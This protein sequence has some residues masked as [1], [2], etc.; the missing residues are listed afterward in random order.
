MAALARARP[1]H[2]GLDADEAAAL[3]RAALVH[4]LGRVGVPNGVWDKPGPLSDAEWER[5]RLHSYYTERILARAPALAPL[6]ATAGLH[7]ERLDGSGYHRG[8]AAAA[9]RRAARLL[10][11]ADAYQAMTQP[12]PHRPA[13]APDEAAAEIGAEVAAGRLDRAAAGAVLHAAG[14]R[15]ALPR[16]PWPAGLSEREVEVLRLLCRGLSKRQVAEALVVAPATVDHHVRHIYG[17]IGVS[18]RA[19]AA[20]FALEHGLLPE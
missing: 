5:V 11:V 2:A 12:R 1:P 17:K 20:V 9:L 7:H 6:G 15:G 13:R 18:T 8:G 14:Q 10:A 3:R 19:G 4:D 16:R